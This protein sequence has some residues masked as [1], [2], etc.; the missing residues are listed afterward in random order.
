M[1]GIIGVVTTKTPAVLDL[2]ECLVALQHRGQDAAGMV[3]LDKDFFHEKRGEG[4]VREVFTS[5]DMQRLKGNA[6]LGH[7]RYRTAGPLSIESTQPFFSS[8]P[9]GMYLVHNGNLTNTEELRSFVTKRL[10]RYLRS[11]SDSEILL[12]V[13][14]HEVEET[15]R[16]SPKASSV[17]S[18]LQAVGKTMDKL[19]GAYACIVLIDGVGL[20]AFRDP[21]GIRPLVLGSRGKGP[22]RDWAFASETAAFPAADFETERDLNPGEAVLVDLKGKV[23]S[24]QARKGELNPCI[25]EYI[26]TARPDSIMNGISVYKARLRLGRLLGKRILEVGVELDVVIPVPDSARPEALEIAHELDIPHREGLVRNRYVGRTFIMPDQTMRVASVRRKMSAMPLEFEGKR[27]LLVDDSIVRGTTITKI[28]R[29]CREA[30]AREVHVAS[31]AP[32]VKFQNVYGVDIP[33]RRELISHGRTVEQVR[34]A[35]GADGLYYQTIGDMIEAARA[36]NPDITRFEDSVFTGDYVT[37]DVKT[38]YLRELENHNHH[39]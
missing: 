31:A 16:K 12:R 18:V 9:Y 10:R 25:F 3:T 15:L 8:A 7:V 20:L 29:M 17:R 14:A 13:F 37:G 2:H 33:T 19:H 36:G 34:K 21:H 38:A 39:G 5:E 11:S 1:C 27:V 4:L 32:P 24:F 22:K 30:G 35:I 28:I 23:H 6:G 26:Y